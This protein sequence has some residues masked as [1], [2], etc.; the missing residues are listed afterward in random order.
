MINSVVQVFMYLLA[1]C[2]IWLL[3]KNVY[4]DFLPIFKLCCLGFLLLDYIRFWNIFWT[5][6]LS[7]FNHVCLSASPW[8]VACQAPLSMAFSR[9]VYWSG[10][11]CPSPGGFPDLGIEPESLM[12]PA[13]TGCFFTISTT[14]EA[15]ILAINPL[16]GIWL[17]YLLVFS[18]LPS[19]FVYGF[20]CY[21]ETFGLWQ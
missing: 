7:H 13:S 1:I 2:I 21:V 5:C 3:W 4:W 11:L 17:T 8:T 9:Q 20:L 19:Q 6:V 12:S 10:W 15:P 16:L 18:S 14:W